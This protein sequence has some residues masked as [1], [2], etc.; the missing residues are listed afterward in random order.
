MK[1]W[2]NLY[3]DKPS[4]SY[5]LSRS[6]SML[7][8]LRSERSAQLKKRSHTRNTENM[9]DARN[10]SSHGMHSGSSTPWALDRKQNKTND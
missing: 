7:T 8:F 9:V 1:S 6:Y 5:S 4:S 3:P 2:N 10:S